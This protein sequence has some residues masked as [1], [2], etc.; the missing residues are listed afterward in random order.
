VEVASAEPVEPKSTVL[1]PREP[2]VLVDEARLR[3]RT[4]GGPDPAERGCSAMTSLEQDRV[5]L[6]M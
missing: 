2:S 3:G 6:G 5:A 4:P 1:E